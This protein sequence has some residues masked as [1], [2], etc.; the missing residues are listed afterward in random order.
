MRAIDRNRSASIAFLVATIA[1]MAAA[2]SVFAQ[3]SPS[4]RQAK[5]TVEEVARLYAAANPDH[6]ALLHRLAT[7]RDLCPSYG[8]A[9]KLSACL[10]RDLGDDSKARVYTDRAVLNGVADLAC[11]SASRPAPIIDLGP[12]ADKWALVVGIAQFAD[13]EIPDLQ[14]TAKDAQDFYDFLIDPQGGRFHPDRVTLLRDEKATR[15][16]ILVALNDIVV[17]AGERDLV[18]IYVSS[19]G[20]PAVDAAGL[21]GVGYIVTHD[22]VWTNVYVDSLGFQDFSEQ[23]ARI[24]A[25]RKVTFLDTCFSGQA[26]AEGAKNL[27]IG[28]L[29]V[30]ESTA[31][32]FTSAEGS[33]LITS[34]G[35]E[36][37]SWE[38]ARLQ[39]SYFT[40]YLL[41]ALRRGDEPPPLD[42]VFEELTRHVAATVL[43]EKRA[44][45]N[46][47]LHPRNL[48]ADLRIGA[49]PTVAPRVRRPASR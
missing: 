13:P 4:C 3:A 12:I 34:S 28:A 18:V 19:H 2:P 17:G 47:Q 45:Q 5:Q 33:Y 32:L 15:E 37:K 1:T 49:P 35:P 42:E 21:E 39:N 7:A 24:R 41:A 10:A 11:A 23:I 48:P 16:A 38:S 20:S 36:E 9:W 14:F 29:G 46:P 8:E 40:Y 25:R 22:T 43:D 27:Q 30:A 31:R 44:R 6:E 26:M